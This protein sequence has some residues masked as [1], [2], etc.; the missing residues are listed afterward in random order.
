MVYSLLIVIERV[1]VSIDLPSILIP[2]LHN[3]HYLESTYSSINPSTLS[4]YSDTS[5]SRKASRSISLR[6]ISINQANEREKVIKQVTEFCSIVKNHRCSVVECQKLFETSSSLRIHMRS[7]TGEKPFPC[8]YCTH[9]FTTK[10]NMKDHER[11]H[12]QAR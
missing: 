9:A 10:G 4:S 12:V 7:H 8:R 1:W 6:I 3:S 2:H 5:F 11:R